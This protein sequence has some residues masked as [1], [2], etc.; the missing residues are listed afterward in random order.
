MSLFSSQQFSSSDIINLTNL[1][2]LLVVLFQ[3]VVIFSL[4]SLKDVYRH[5][6]TQEKE[7]VQMV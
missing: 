1:F 6:V 3:Y 7:I 2:G 4:K 5:Q